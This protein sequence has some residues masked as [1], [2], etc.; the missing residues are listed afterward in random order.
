MPFPDH[1]ASL[2]DETARAK[3]FSDLARCSP[4]ILAG[5]THA[6]GAQVMEALD[7]RTIEGVAASKYVLWAQ[8]IATLAR[9]EKTD[10]PNPALAA[11]LD[12]RWEKKRLRDLAGASPSVLTGMSDYEAKLLEEALGVRTLQDLA[13][14]RHI[15][16]AQAIARL[17]EE[18]RLAPTQ[19]AA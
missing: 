3:S 19:K 10:L 13:T 9:H 8:A 1:L 6:Q 2:I 14:N 11:I 12:A 7:T 16:L 5:L 15:L 18:E 17:A 4:G